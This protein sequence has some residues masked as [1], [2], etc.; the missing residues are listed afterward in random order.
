[1]VC[2]WLFGFPAKH[3][4]YEFLFCSLFLAPIVGFDSMPLRLHVKQN[5]GSIH[6]YRFETLRGRVAGNIL[7]EAL[8]TK[9]LDENYA[10]TSKFTSAFHHDQKAALHV[11]FMRQRS[12]FCKSGGIILAGAPCSFSHELA[13]NCTFKFTTLIVSRMKD[14]VMNEDMR[15][16]FA[17]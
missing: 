7:R 1:M 14:C 16:G 8:V 9:R 5:A 2:F 6:P 13:E 4:D 15:R 10:R 3:I 17:D 12:L 11:V